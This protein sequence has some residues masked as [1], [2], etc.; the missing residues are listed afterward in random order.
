MMA[1]PESDA[2]KQAQQDYA[3]A[4]A[5]VQQP[6][7]PIDHAPADPY[8]RTLTLVDG[9]LEIAHGSEGQRDLTFIVGK[10]ELAQGIEVLIGTTQGSDIFNLLFGFDI[11]QTLMLPRN[12][13]E[14][15]ELVRLSVV[16]A[17][18]Q[19]PRIRQIQAVAFVD[20]KAYLLI[21]PEVTPEQQTALAREQRL[22]R[23]WKL[24]VLLDTRLGDQVTAAVAG[25]GP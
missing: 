1:N 13:R 7:W 11:Q 24:D 5:A 18:A 8:G 21:H 6:E 22:S 9:D 10:L 3:N 25:V 4:L 15:R 12:V 23:R 20:E 2:L 17:L 14:M 16:K 19:E